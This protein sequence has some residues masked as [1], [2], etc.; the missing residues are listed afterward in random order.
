MVFGRENVGMENIFIGNNILYM[1]VNIMKVL[2]GI[3]IFV[4]MVG[5]KFSVKI[6]WE[7]EGNLEFVI[8][9]SCSNCLF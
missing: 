3:S 9:G 1:G 6:M 5:N 4:N 7:W 8:V 2:E